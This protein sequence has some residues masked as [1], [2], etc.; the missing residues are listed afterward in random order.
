MQRMLRT[1]LSPTGTQI[2]AS[3]LKVWWL[4]LIFSS[5]WICFLTDEMKFQWPKD[6]AETKEVTSQQLEWLLKKIRR[7]MKKYGLF[8]PIRKANPY[9]RMAKAIEIAYV[10]PNLLNREFETQ[11]PRKVLLP[12]ITYIINGTV[13]H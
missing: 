11:G 5:N 10:V 2:S 1:Y 8:C 7:L 6:A 3:N 9:R 4:W 12:D 13:F